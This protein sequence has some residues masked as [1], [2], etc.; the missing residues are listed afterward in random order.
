MDFSMR[1]G[2]FSNPSRSG[3]SPMRRSNSRYNS[4]VDAVSS[5]A[6]SNV[7]DMLAIGNLPLD[8]AGIYATC[9]VEGVIARLFN[10]HPLQMCGGETKKNTVNLS[11]EILRRRNRFAKTLQRVQIRVVK[12]INQIH[13]CK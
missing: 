13:L 4:C 2:V 8:K 3:S 10:M 1:S 6:E 7:A 12:T 11:A 5:N 9:I